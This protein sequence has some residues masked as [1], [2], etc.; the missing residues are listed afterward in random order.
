LSV[1]VDA[2]LDKKAEDV[3]VLDMNACS[4]FTDYFVICHGR[5]TRQVRAISDKVE[6]KLKEAKIR[7]AHIEGYTAGE[8]ILMDYIDFV[9]HIFTG[10]KRNYYGIEK[11]W[12]DAP[13]VPLKKDRQEA[14]DK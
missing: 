9:V 12:A 14:F 8:W 3:A 4:S 1:V 5:G 7:P 10:E 13:R 11:L 6:E 2:A